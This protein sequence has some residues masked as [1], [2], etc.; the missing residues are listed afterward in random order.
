MIK[1]I[2]HP[3]IKPDT[4]EQRAYQMSLIDCALNSST[5]VV[6]PTGLGKT[7]VALIVSVARLGRF[8]GK[9]LMLAPTKPLVEQHT[10]FFKSVLAIDENE[11]ISLTGA[12]E[13][14]KR[15][16]LWNNA[17]IIISTPQVIENDLLSYR[18][19]LKD[20]VHITFDET[21]RAVGNYAYTYI[22]N[23]YHE[24]AKNP[25]VLGLTA[26]PGSNDE[27]IQGICET[28]RIESVAI[29]TE[30]DS[31]VIPYIYEKK[32][33]W[34]K[35]NLSDE[36]KEIRDKVLKVLENKFE[37]LV[38]IGY[39]IPNGANATKKDLLSFQARLQSKLRELGN[40][41]IY[42]AIS[43]LAE[44]MKLSHALEVIETQGIGAT[45]RYF[46]K[47]E[48]ESL[49]KSGSK[50]SKRL[51]NDV[52]VKQIKQDLKDCTIEHPKL[53][54]VR[55]IVSNHVKENLDSRIIV[56]TNF[57]D[58]ADLVANSLSELDGIRPKKFTGQGSRY[59]DK[60][61]TQ[62]KQIEIIDKFKDGD[63][64]VLVSTSV[65]EEGLDIPATDLVVFYEPIPSE[66]RLI[67]RKGRTGRKSKGKIITLITKGTRDEAFYHISKRNE[68]VMQE[69]IRSISKD[70]SNFIELKELPQ[71]KIYEF[72][73]ELTIYIDQRETRSEVVQ[74]IEKLGCHIIVKQIEV[75][76]YVVSNRMAIE[77][78][79]GVDFANSLI[80]RK[81]FE[82]ISN[83]SRVYEKSILIIEGDGLFTAR[84]LNPNSIY[85]ALASLSISFGVSIFYTRDSS[86]SASLIK[87]LAKRE[88]IDEKREVSLHGKKSA[89][90]LPEQQEYVI[91]SISDIGP[92]AARNLLN[93]FGSVKGVITANKE[94]LMEVGGIGLKTVEKIREVVESEYKR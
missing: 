75:G 34:I 35:V 10:K 88:Q 46:D 74:L 1:Y 82:Q 65:A 85:G 87:L 12:I 57:R 56:F 39:L 26:S 9:V 84:Q 73:E 54:V 23:K 14:S 70:C 41:A 66:I 77:R 55:D 43:I 20:V 61:L 5:L 19:N 24:T 91:S 59:K 50:A 44:I 42:S 29:K 78:K 67:Q 63:Y 62:K 86:D 68:K 58:T 94:K 53:S 64:N 16:D 36:I 81:I 25:L 72:D 76:D 21:H 13:S 47:L 17:K 37:K 15:A 52:A 51:F 27:K 89:M 45:I 40:P 79:T 92:K 60:G 30:E 18:I 8:N 2:K 93:H 33:E 49:S 31:D 22:A 11:I 4:V 83:M 3:L 28:L 32:I 90:L 7:I 48:N 69:K 38:S 80:D 6:I 71:K